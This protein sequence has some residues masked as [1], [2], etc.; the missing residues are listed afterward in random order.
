MYLVTEMCEGGTLEQF[1]KV[2]HD[3]HD[4]QRMQARFSPMCDVE[5]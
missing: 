3:V 5:S 4:L 2:G 1:M